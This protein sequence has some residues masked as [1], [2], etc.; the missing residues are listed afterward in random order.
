MCRHQA[1]GTEG[2]KGKK[3]GR[4]EGKEVRMKGRGKEGDIIRFV[5]SHSDFPY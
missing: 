5:L 1:M 2:G 4:E 3:K